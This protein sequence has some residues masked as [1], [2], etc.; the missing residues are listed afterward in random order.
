[1]LWCTV[2]VWCA[3]WRHGVL[4]C[5]CD[6]RKHWNWTN[7]RCLQFPRIILLPYLEYGYIKI[8]LF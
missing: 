8:L 4:H 6:F 1:M 3:V 2:T 7:P 5:F